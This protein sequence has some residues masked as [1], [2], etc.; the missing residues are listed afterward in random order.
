MNPTTVNTLSRTV[1]QMLE[2][3]GRDLNSPSLIAPKDLKH[4]HDEYVEK[5]NRQRRKEQ[6]EK[7]RKH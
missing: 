7:E 4:A 1:V 2:R 3:M 5:V 6:R